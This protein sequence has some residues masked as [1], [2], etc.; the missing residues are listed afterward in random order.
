MKQVALRRSLTL[1][2]LTFYGLGTIVGAGI[3]VLIGEVAGVAGTNLP[4]AFLVAGLIAGL[5]GASYA[6]LAA[7][8]P[9]SA[10]AALY[11]DIAFNRAWL[12]R[13]TGYLIAFIGIVSA[14]TISR[15][16]LGYLDLYVELPAALVITLLVAAMTAVACWGIREAAWLI[17]LITLIECGGILYAGGVALSGEPVTQLENLSLSPSAIVLGSFLA[18]YAFIGFEDVVN[19]AEEVREPETNMPRAIFLAM[20]LATLL[21]VGLAFIALHYV[22]LELLSNSRSPLAV[23]AADSQLAVTLIGLISLVAVVNGA[24]VQIIMAARVLYGMAQRGLVSAFFGRVHP[25]TQ[26]PVL[27]TLIVSSV[28]LV[29]ALGFPLVVLASITSAVTLVIF[30]LV[31]V[32]LIRIRQKDGP[33]PVNLPLLI[34]VMGCLASAGLLILQVGQWLGNQ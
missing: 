29:F 28:L 34:P 3:Y 24:L 11:I 27:G 13:I 31:N 12:S 17:T 19:V 9:K 15:G 32:A 20:A 4:Y 33:G 18:F 22:D 25:G 2:L 5:T 23:I 8:F 10:G 7:R 14:A 16:F 21:Y 1:P 6:E 30:S 26:T